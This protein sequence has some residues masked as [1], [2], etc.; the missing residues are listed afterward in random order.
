MQLCLQ[1]SKSSH[2]EADGRSESATMLDNGTL[3]RSL[4]V[5][6]IQLDDPAPLQQGL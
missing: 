4:L 6:A 1:R 5:V 2:L 3:E